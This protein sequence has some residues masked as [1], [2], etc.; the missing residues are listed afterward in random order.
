MLPIFLKMLAQAR[1]KCLL[2]DNITF[3][4]ADAYRLDS[5]A[6]EFDGLLAMFW[7]SHVPRERIDEFLTGVSSQIRPGAAVFMADN[8]LV[9]GLGGALI[10]PAGEQDTYKRRFL[11]DGS[12][13]DVLKNYYNIAELRSLFERHG[14]VIALER[15]RHYWS[16]HYCTGL[17]QAKLG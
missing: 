9:Q 11:P 5:V 8:V 14:A 10:Q 7:F 4:R 1:L 3:Q 13:R 6:G 12:A 2:P 16:I 15:G 17:S